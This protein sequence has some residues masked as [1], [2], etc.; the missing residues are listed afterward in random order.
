MNFNWVPKTLLY[1]RLF[2]GPVMIYWTY[3]THKAGIVLL[4][5]LWLGLLSDIFDGIIARKLGIATEWL[6]KADAWFDIVFWLCA[7]YCIYLIRPELFH[8][9]KYGIIALFCFEPISDLIYLFRFRAGGCAHN[10]ASKLWGLILL[11]TFSI[12]L[13]GGNPGVLFIIAIVGGLVSQID[14][15]LIASILPKPECDIPS[16]Y[17]A[18]LRRQGKSFKRYKMFN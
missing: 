5:S 6:R 4:V 15:I 7:G 14:R 10:W 12:I 1:F 3:T 8:E 2:L 17:Q 18:N 9:Y 16:F 11:A 13:A